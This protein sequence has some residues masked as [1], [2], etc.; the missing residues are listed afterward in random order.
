MRKDIRDMN[1]EE[2]QREWTW[3]LVEIALL[4]FAMLLIT[5]GS[6]WAVPASMLFVFIL[7]R[8]NRGG[9]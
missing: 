9:L 2:L 3:T 7:L 4:L 5:I 1:K 6:W 8:P